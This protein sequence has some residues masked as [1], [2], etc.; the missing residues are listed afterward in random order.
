MATAGLPASV[1]A[2]VNRVPAQSDFAALIKKYG[3]AAPAEHAGQIFVNGWHPSVACD[4]R[5]RF[6][7]SREDLR[8]F[9]GKELIIEYRLVKSAFGKSDYVKTL[10][11]VFRDRIMVGDGHNEFY[12]PKFAFGEM[13]SDPERLQFLAFILQRICENRRISL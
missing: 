9:V 7:W 3:H 10:V 8:Y 4:K 2:S 12:F 11:D 1:S 13:A 5:R 6:G